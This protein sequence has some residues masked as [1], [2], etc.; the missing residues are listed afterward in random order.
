MT[1]RVEP[2]VLTATVRYRHAIESCYLNGVS[3]LVGC[4][5]TSLPWGS[6]VEQTYRNLIQQSSEGRGGNTYVS[7]RLG[8]RMVYASNIFLLVLRISPL[9]S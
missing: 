4:S 1:E 5:D 6:K 8:F 9:G 2:V 7:M 3:L